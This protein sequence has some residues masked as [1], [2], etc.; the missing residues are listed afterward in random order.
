MSTPANASD[1]ST[2]LKHKA[3]DVKAW[4][5]SGTAE[6]D[7]LIVRKRPVHAE[8]TEFIAAEKEREP[9]RVRFDLTV[10]YGEKRWIVR[11]EMAFYSL[12]WVS[13][14][15]IKMPGLMFNALAQDGMPTRIAYY[16]LKY[17]QSLDAMDPQTW[18]KGW[19]QKILKHPDIKHLFAHKVEVPAEE[20]EE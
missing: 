3:V 16:N 12:R 15:S 5:E 8:I 2:L 10:Q 11:L 18:C 14:D 20:Y 1:I 6:M 7:D 17:T 9:D 13:E 19:I 4:F